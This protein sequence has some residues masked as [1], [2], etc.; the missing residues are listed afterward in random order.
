MDPPDAKEGESFGSSRQTLLAQAL[1]DAL[2]QHIAFTLYHVSSNPTVCAPIFATPPGSR[3]ERTYCESQF[4]TLSIRPEDAISSEQP[5]VFAI[6]VLVYSTVRLTTLFV[7]KADSTGFLSLP[8][9]TGTAASPLKTI[10]TRFISFLAEE[11]RRR[12]VKTVVSLFARAQDQYLFPGSIENKHK[13]VLDDRGLIRWWCRVLDPMLPGTGNAVV[14]D[15]RRR[16]YVVVPGLDKYETSSLFPPTAKADLPGRKRW[17]HG[18]PLRDIS[19]TPNAPPRCLI[20]RF[21]DDPKARFLDEL[22]EELSEASRNETLDSP[23]KGRNAGQWFSVKT[24]EHFWEAM[25]FRQ[26]CSSGRLVG[27][28]WIVFDLDELE[29][30]AVDEP[31]RPPTPTRP[32]RS[33]SVTTKTRSLKLTGPIVPRRPHIKTSTARLSIKTQ[34][35]TSRHY[36]WPPT[37]R[38]QVVL[39][40]KDYKR[41][42]DYLLR[43]DFANPT[44][45]AAS[46]TRWLDEVAA[47]A[48][49]SGKEAEWGEH[50]VGRK[51]YEGVASSYL[52]APTS[53]TINALGAELVKRRKKTD[54]EEDGLPAQAEGDT[55]AGPTVLS[56]G[57][58]RKKPKID[59]E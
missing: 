10:A 50:M 17:I 57:L 43:L 36:S 34:P 49:L 21:P 42:N 38:G 52:S 56:S 53:G 48:G 24:L 35:A 2:P 39:D 18:H 9:R 15:P 47:A 27:F 5:L 6:E 54:V 46:T 31:E 23:S 45:A 28:I 41:V 25:E 22:D 11:R 19:A 20:P 40:E 14:Q 7:S 26:E 30:Q 32:S 13:H 33:E 59:R 44:V 58:V 29:P 55:A 16:G 1:A 12:G 51:I 37:S 4:I 8:S 3:P